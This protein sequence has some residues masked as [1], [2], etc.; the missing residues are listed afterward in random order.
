ML[1]KD[2]QQ[3]HHDIHS[4]QDIGHSPKGIG[5]DII[6]DD[7]RNHVVQHVDL[8]GN[9]IALRIA[10]GIVDGFF[11]AVIHAYNGRPCKNRDG[12]GHEPSPK[13]AISVA[14]SHSRQAGTVN[15]RMG[16]IDIGQDDRKG[17][18]AADHDCIEKDFPPP[19]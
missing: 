7:T 12:N 1:R 3:G 2:K 11:A 16:H 6:H 17:S 9:L 8:Y 4:G 13:N 18:H 5:F 15:S 14:E 19:P 10:K